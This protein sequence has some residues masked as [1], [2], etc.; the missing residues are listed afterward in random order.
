MKIRL[1]HDRVVVKREPEERKTAGGQRQPE[2]HLRK[3]IAVGQ[4]KFWT[5]ADP[6]ADQG[7]E[8]RPPKCGVRGSTLPGDG[9][10][11]LS[12]PSSAGV[13]KLAM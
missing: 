12:G 8:T 3:F 11:Q 7:D 1:L 9:S 6:R 2:T 4:G 13:D 5:W 10:R